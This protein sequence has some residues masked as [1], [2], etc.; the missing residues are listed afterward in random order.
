MNIADHSGQHVRHCRE[1][2]RIRAHGAR[3]GPDAF[4]IDRQLA[5]GTHG[6][7]ATPRQPARPTGSGDYYPNC[8]AARAAGPTP[9]YRSQCAY[10]RHLDRDGD[11]IACEQ[12]GATCWHKKAPPVSRQGSLHILVASVQ[13]LKPA[14]M[15]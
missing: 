14:P 1:K 3:T 13:N 8:A 4:H 12:S 9:I 5:V 15:P 6:G 2:W 10:G 11:G 7:G